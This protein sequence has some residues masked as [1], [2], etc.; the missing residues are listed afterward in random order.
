MRTFTALSGALL[1]STAPVA[2]A[3]LLG[4]GIGGLGGLG[5][6]LNGS[7]GSTIGGAGSIGDTLDSVRSGTSGT[8][9]GAASSSGKQSVDRKSGQAK[10]ER[11]AAANGTGVVTSSLTGP[12]TS[13]TSR[14][15][16]SDSANA[17]GS[18]EAQ[19][20]GADAVRGT[21]QSGRETARQ[22]G[23]QAAEQGNDAAGGAGGKG[24]GLLSSSTA[25]LG[26]SLTGSSNASGAGS[27]GASGSPIDSA[28]DASG[29]GAGAFTVTSGMPVL[30]P[31]GQRIGRVRRV[32]SN[33]RGEAEQL[34]IKVDGQL[35]ALPAANFSASGKAVTSA[36]S[37]GQIKRVGAEQ[38]ASKETKAAK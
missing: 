3:Q 24:Q 6:T 38:E 5:G 11:N 12:A 36:M 10:I 26:G 16:G 32:I 29:S 34:L 18:A 14:A 4:G 35:A 2:H 31:D 1:L 37:E 23:P 20:I 33:S 22:A 19:L 9:R 13:L 30:S 15:S 21:L 25:G 7:I 17:S 8:L 27:A 28:A